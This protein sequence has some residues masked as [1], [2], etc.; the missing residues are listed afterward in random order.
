M[1]PF[2]QWI[3]RGRNQAL[4]FVLIAIATSPIFWPGSILAAAA[5]TLVGLRL[6]E[7][8]GTQ[9]WFWGLLPTIAVAAYSDSYV[10]LLI[11]T[12]SWITSL[13]LRR[14]TSWSYSLVS[15][16]ICSLVAAVALELLA[17]SSLQ[18][19]V[20]VYAR[21]MQEAQQQMADA[22]EL[23]ALLPDSI[24]TP[25]VAGLLAT[26]TLIGSFF[27]V[28]L[29]RSWQAKLYNPGGFQREFH[30]L[31][32]SRV[33]S[34]GFLL[35]AGVLMNLGEQYL[36]WI[37]IAFFPFL[38]AGVALF[39]AFALEKKIAIPWYVLFYIVLTLWDPLK[40]I[41]VLVGIID[42]IADFR[43]RTRRT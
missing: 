28:I 5:V 35:L 18:S 7:K 26:F 3:M 25:F 30:A 11:I 2:A 23:K 16:T 33:E 37:W 39:H 36:T 19:Y 8:Q 9:L 32:L 10:P 1:L 43:S 17:T 38:I 29:G 42:S 22:P 12:S 27:A 4:A 34:I 24:E 40:M 20:D 6:G 14:T 13:I 15:L 31:K 41:L 21:F